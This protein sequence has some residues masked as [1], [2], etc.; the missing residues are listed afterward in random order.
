MREETDPPQ[1]APSAPVM[2]GTWNVFGSSASSV[3]GSQSGPATGDARQSW[4]PPALEEAATLFP[5][6]EVL[7]LLGRGGMGAVYQARQIE[8]DRLVAI[9]LL[10][11]EISVDKSFSDRFRRE[12][13]AMARLHHPN[14][15][16]VFDFGAT[17][18]GH[19]FFVMEFVDGAD[20]LQLI[21]ESRRIGVSDLDC[22][23]A[24]K[25]VEQVCTALEYAHEKGIVHR[26]IKPA[27]VMVDAKHRVKV[28]DF[29]L[30]RL[31]EPGTIDLG[32][33][34]T[35]MV[36]GTPDYMAPEQMRDMNVDHRADI[37]SVGIMLYE[38][39]CGEVPKG[40]FAPPSRRIGCDPRLDVI[41]RRATQQAA[42]NRYQST[43]EM[44]AAVEGV[45][46]RRQRQ[47]SK[48]NRLLASGAVALAA[49]AAGIFFL[50]HLQNSKNSG[51]PGP[52]GKKT[53]ELS[54]SEATGKLSAPT[55]LAATP[56]A[57]PA[58]ATAGT[59]PASEASL[60]RA[61]AAAQDLE[62]TGDW[63][64][65]LDAWLQIV[66]DH[67]DL[68]ASKE[69]LA[70]LFKQLKVSKPPITFEAFQKIRPQITDAAQ[71]DI[72]EA[73]LVLG[74]NL[75][76]QDPD[77]ARDWYLKAAGKGNA[78]AEY[79]LG[80]MSYNEGASN[81]LAAADAIKHYQAAMD[82]GDIRGTVALSRCYRIG[83]G[84]EKDLRRSIQLLREAA[85]AG[86]PVAMNDLGDCYLRGDGVPV[87]LNEAF[88][89][90]S[91]S[92]ELGC[93][94][95]KGNLGELYMRGGGVTADPKKATEIFAEGAKAG[96][97]FCMVH[98]AHSLEFGEG[99]DKKFL[100]AAYWY[101][102]AAQ[103]GDPKAV[104]W[105]KKHAVV[106]PDAN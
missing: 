67:P 29:G 1:S 4:V 105:C 99:I 64:K 58:K 96:N 21:H 56:V 54:A 38:M 85:E 69:H 102:K 46:S 6:Y 98:Y 41:V 52:S 25:I 100:E 16:T 10:P 45:R 39:L 72:P 51:T 35:G 71:L 87:D 92:A 8:L 63:G 43:Q 33:T 80:A 77:A 62:G 106:V 94:I 2:P 27:N 37:Y 78:M 40:S 14:I 44:K 68:Q 18:Q 15:I 42:E 89:L 82:R 3:S 88:K 65:T 22:D 66:R 53:A 93:E 17:R 73:M 11:L 61:V 86:D 12:A 13:Q 60:S 91:R 101:G 83:F 97:V 31:L 55:A 5:G 7:Q 103:A 19:L 104:L 95:A 81:P 28:A 84:V 90:I 26:D 23:D 49:A 70:M 20:L 48:R 47:I 59:T 57:V 36:M 34:M 9:K 76:N 32:H 79:A 75:V 74:D 50:P 30:A 24:L